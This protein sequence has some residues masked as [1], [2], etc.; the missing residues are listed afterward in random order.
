MSKLESRLLVLVLILGL[1]TVML[2]CSQKD[3]STR[4]G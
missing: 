2:S 1:L 3:N 4:F